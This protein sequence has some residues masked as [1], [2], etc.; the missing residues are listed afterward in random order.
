[1]S[2]TTTKPLTV[3]TVFNYIGFDTSEG[4][5]RCSYEV[6]GYTFTE[7]F[8]LE[9]SWET[10]ASQEAARIIFLLAGISY[11]KSHAPAVIDLGDT[12]IR[13][14]ERKFLREYYIGGLG[15]F[16]Y[17][18]SLSLSSLEIVGG[19]E[20]G[21]APSVDEATQANPLICFGGGID[22]IVTVELA[23]KSHPN[24]KLFV[25]S[26]AE[27]RF[28]PL[29]QAAA[30]TG[31]EI[32]RAKRFLD[33]QILKSSELG[34]L[35][36]HV[37][38][39]GIVSAV[40][41]AAATMHGCSEVIMSNEASSSEGNLEYDGR[42]INHQYSKSLEFEN[43]FR[44]VLKQAF[45]TNPDWFSYLRHR[46]E[47]WI[48]DQF[49]K[50]TQYHS[51]FRS[52]NRAFHI[53]ES[54]REAT[55]CGECDKC[56]FIDL[57]LAPFMA[58]DAL[59]EMFNDNEPLENPGMFDV[60]KSLVSEEPGFNKPFECVGDINECRQAVELADAREDR[61]S[62]HNLERLSQLFPATTKDVSQLPHNLPESYATRH[63]V[64]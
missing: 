40:A 28:A 35:N 38:V 32:L 64:D 21:E 47:L 24:A 53:D 16:S 30:V 36:G 8:V 19:V 33:P 60:L 18:N 49:A 58:R 46:N 20:A 22:S 25:M 54:K 51:V 13:S 5:L 10:D 62:N 45:G 27:T 11:Y 15:E 4:E 55:W 26:P 48:A 34:F 17:K 61:A 12:E 7:R 31:L 63:I 37:P 59:A 14:G 2:K 3:E 39:T 57:I 42:M 43:L 23:R 56:A 52:C 1:M 41:I 29:E 50:L 6:G 44:T 9:G